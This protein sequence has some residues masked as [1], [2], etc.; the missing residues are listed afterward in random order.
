MFFKHYLTGKKHFVNH[1]F[2]NVY[3]KLKENVFLTMY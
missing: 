2:K 3:K 1:V